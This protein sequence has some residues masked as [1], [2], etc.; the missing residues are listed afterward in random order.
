MSVT[1]PCLQQAR[2]IAL[3]RTSKA[4]TGFFPASMDWE[5]LID[6][7]PPGPDSGDAHLLDGYDFTESNEMGGNTDACDTTIDLDMR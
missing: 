1:T 2:S 5:S 4:A 6:W 3:E 7:L